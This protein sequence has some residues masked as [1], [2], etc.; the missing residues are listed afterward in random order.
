MF[1]RHHAMLRDTL[2]ALSTALRDALR[3]KIANTVAPALYALSRIYADFF[4]SVWLYACI[5]DKI[6]FNS[7]KACS[8]LYIHSNAHNSRS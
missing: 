1:E 8:H 7:M 3:R 4:L 6:F 5:C 2:A